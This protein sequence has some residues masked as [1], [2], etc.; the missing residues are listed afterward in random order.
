MNGS[1]DDE[2][3][4]WLDVFRKL[5]KASEWICNLAASEQG[6][7]PPGIHHMGTY[8]K[9]H[10]V[11]EQFNQRTCIPHHNLDTLSSTL[12]LRFWQ[13]GSLFCHLLS[14]FSTRCIWCRVSESILAYN[15]GRKVLRSCH[16][17]ASPWWLY[18]NKACR[19]WMVNVDN[20][21]GQFCFAFSGRTKADPIQQL[22][23]Q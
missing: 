22:K 23:S 9:Y 10:H 15:F 18:S 8:F 19:S 12:R 4:I 17:D 1:R 6:M 21:L 16:T 11:D 2:Q 3:K 20:F 7:Q 5:C 13:A 14:E